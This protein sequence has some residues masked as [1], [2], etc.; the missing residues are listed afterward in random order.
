MLCLCLFVQSFVHVSTA[1][2]NCDKTVID[3]IIYDPICDPDIAKIVKNM[4]KK[5]IDAMSVELLVKLLKFWYKFLLKILHFRKF[6]Q[7]RI[8]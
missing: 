2:S 5:A 1:F 4:P 8:L 7:T 6:I 3:E